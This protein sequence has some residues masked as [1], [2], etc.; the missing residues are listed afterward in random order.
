VSGVDE[1]LFFAGVTGQAAAVAAGD[2]SSRELTA[3]V[4]DRIRAYDGRLNAFTVVMAEQA[5]AEAAERDALPA[6]EH[7]PLHGVP[8]AI[9]EEVDIAGQVTTFGGRAAA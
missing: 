2:V 6:T 7:G 4:L 8:V 3:A 5:L 9:K 1:D